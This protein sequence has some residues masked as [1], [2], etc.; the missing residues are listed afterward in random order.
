[1]INTPLEEDEQKVL[2]QYLRLKKI[3]HFA[4]MNEN[5]HSFSNRGLAMKL[6]A[7]AKS[8]G[9]VSGTPDLIVMLDNKMLFIE[10]KRV[11]G[12]TTSKAQKEFINKA[13]QY[14]Y[15]I[16]KVCK[17]AKEAIAFIEENR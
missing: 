3:F 12:S 1:M 17:G 4:P 5:K 7:K 14:P 9:K 2:V 13:N 6:E 10:L 8:M 15:A 16:A 11:K